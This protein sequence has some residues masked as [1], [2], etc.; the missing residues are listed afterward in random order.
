MAM[1]TV[2]AI[3]GIPAKLK[4]EATAPRSATIQ[5]LRLIAN[6]P[7]ISANML[8]INVRIIN[9]PNTKKLWARA[10]DHKTIKSE[11]PADTILST[12]PMAGIGV[13]GFVASQVCSI[14]FPPVVLLSDVFLDLL[15]LSFAYLSSSGFEDNLTSSVLK[16]LQHK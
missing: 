1:R 6:M 14:I 12:P 11:M 5:Y 8:E 10:T 15:Q 9:P 7:P 2:A 16:E 13:D 3:P 4:I